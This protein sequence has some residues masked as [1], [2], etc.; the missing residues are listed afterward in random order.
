MKTRNIVMYVLVGLLAV[1]AIGGVIYGVTTHTEPGLLEGVPQWQRGDFP[2]DVSATTYR[3]D[4][5]EKLDQEHRDAL[6]HTLDV[7]N[8]RLGFNALDWADGEPADVVIIIGM[9]FDE[10]WDHPGGHSEIAHTGGRAQRCDVET[11]NTPGQL[12]W[13]VLYHEFGHCFGLAH[14][15]YTLSIMFPEQ[16]QM[17][18][19]PPWFSDDDRALLRELYAPD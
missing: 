8:S 14:D 3:A 7:V 13:Q 15:D 5:V 1:V 18:G 19:L 16:R 4:D 12:L 9:P 10:S 17:E 11:S 2:L 6:G